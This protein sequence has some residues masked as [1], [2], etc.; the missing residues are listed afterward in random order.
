VTR[1]SCLAT[2]KCIFKYIFEILLIIFCYFVEIP[3][4]HQS[5]LDYFWDISRDWESAK[6]DNSAWDIGV[7]VRRDNWY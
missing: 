3:A 2:A 1:T 5:L 7:N 6:S 4:K